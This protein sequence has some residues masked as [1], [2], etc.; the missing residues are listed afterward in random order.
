MAQRNDTAI[1]SGLFRISAE[2]GTDAA[3]P[4]PPGDR[5]RHSRPPDRRV[6]AAAVLPDPGRE[7]RRR[8]RHGGARLPAAGRPGFLIARERRGHFVNPDVL[9]TPAKPARKAG[10]SADADRLESA[11]ADCGHRNAAA[12]QAGQLDQVVLPVR[13]WPVRPGAV[14]DRRM[15]RMQPHGA[16]R[17]GDPQL[18]G[19]H[20]R[21][22][23]PAADRADPGAAVAAA[24]HLRQSRRDHRHAGR[25]ERALHAGDA[26]DEPRASKVAMEDPGYPDARSIFRLAG[27]EIR[28]CRST[29]PASSPRASRPMP[30]SCSSPPATIARPWCRCRPS[31]ART[32]SRGRPA[33]TRSSSRTATTASCSTRRRSR[34]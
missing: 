25:P 13:L 9:A 27:A 18:G 11:P 21:P 29:S 26:A 31:A 24:R 5:R 32:Y 33:T 6:D 34:R 19:R 14:S 8:P 2:S 17:A 4:D 30:A 28:R 16:G 7:A 10:S 20:G 15:A 23:R 3:G 1:W 12:G 22:R